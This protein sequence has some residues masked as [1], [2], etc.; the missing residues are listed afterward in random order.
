MY[1]TR[2]E[3][4]DYLKD[5]QLAQGA[6]VNALLDTIL[7]RASRIVDEICGKQDFGFESVTATT[8]T[9]DGRGTKKLF[10]PDL[11]SITTLECKLDGTQGTVWTAVPSA[12][13]FLEPHTRPSGHPA[14]WVELADQISGSVFTYPQGKGTVRI[15]GTWGWAAVPNEVTEATLEIAVRIFRA[16]AAGFG[17]VV[18]MATD[19]GDQIVITKS[20]AALTHTILKD[21]ARKAAFA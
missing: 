12:D 15:T 2:D 10:V 16:R 3:L 7:T 13:R 5:S 17:D 8:R 21:Y 4:K 1:A 9:F 14:R 20:L 19:A 6:S 18:G 11:Q